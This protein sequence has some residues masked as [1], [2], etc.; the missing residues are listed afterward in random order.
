MEEQLKDMEVKSDDRVRAEQ[1][2]Y[3]EMVVS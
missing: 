3:Q 1:R 2:K